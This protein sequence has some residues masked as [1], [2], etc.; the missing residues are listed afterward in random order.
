MFR[1]LPLPARVWKLDAKTAT[2]FVDYTRPTSGHL[3]A[4]E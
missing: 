1:S 3:L 4:F 2:P